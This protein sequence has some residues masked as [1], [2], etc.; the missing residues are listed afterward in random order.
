ML[1]FGI[2]A[3]VVRQPYSSPA[4]SARKHLGECT[5][6]FILGKI[7]K[8]VPRR[9]NLGFQPLRDPNPSLFPNSRVGPELK[10]KRPATGFENCPVSTL[11]SRFG[12]TSS[13]RHPW[14]RPHDLSYN[15][16]PKSSKAS[17]KSPINLDQNSIENQSTRGKLVNSWARFDS[18]VKTFTKNM[19]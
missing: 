10:H 1:F 15:R 4:S 13:S 18:R 2:L 6:R 12:F 3:H 9:R 17:P 5:S 14:P 8:D 19:D 7:L 16:F 11:T